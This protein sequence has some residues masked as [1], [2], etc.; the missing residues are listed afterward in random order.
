MALSKK[1]IDKMEKSLLAIKR[2][3]IDELVGSS[4]EFE[5]MV[6]DLSPK[7]LADIASDDID[8]KMLEA[9]GQ[10]L[11]KRMKLIDAAIARIK[12]GKY[13]LCA[14]C[15]KPIGEKRLEAIPYVLQC[16]ECKEADEKRAR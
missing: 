16:I 5:E 4:K 3:I 10:T 12:Q 8:R 2:E 11:L 15:G 7:D 13:G 6:T 9:K 1:F 14:K